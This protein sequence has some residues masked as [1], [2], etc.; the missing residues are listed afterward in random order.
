MSVLLLQSVPQIPGGID[1]FVW[2]VW[3]GL[4]GAIGKMYLD[5]RAENKRKDELIDR[6]LKAG[7]EN[8][9]A[10]HRT[11]SLLERESR[12]RN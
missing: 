1:P 11:V 6:L 4:T 9:E 3:V 7:L 5:A 8:A 2:V 12:E 10:T